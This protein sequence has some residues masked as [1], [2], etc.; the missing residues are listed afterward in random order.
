M[1]IPT[2]GIIF[3]IDSNSQVIV[4][5]KILRYLSELLVMPCL[6][7]SLVSCGEKGEKQNWSPSR[8]KMEQRGQQLLAEARRALASADFETAREQVKLMRRECTLALN[9]REEG[10][11]LMDSIDLKQAVKQLEQTDS[12]QLAHPDNAHLLQQSIED[13][14]QKIKFYKRKLE[15]DKQN[16][17]KH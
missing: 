15:H 2:G 5:K 1:A 4:M 9:A 3:T 16:R 11:L 7:L 10:I 13:L 14:S 6:L 17:K 8:V 12:L